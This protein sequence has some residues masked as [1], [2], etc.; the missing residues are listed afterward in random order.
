MGKVLKESLAVSSN[1]NVNANATV[2]ANVVVSF[3][4]IHPLV[5][6][7]PSKEATDLNLKES[8]AV[9]QILLAVQLSK[10]ECDVTWIG[11]CTQTNHCC[12]LFI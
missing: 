11:E 3:K 12:C 4:P 10:S 9:L 8:V 5:L 2:N 7:L 1:A 6:V